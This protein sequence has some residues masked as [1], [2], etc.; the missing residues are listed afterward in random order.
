MSKSA[1]TMNSTIHTSWRLAIMALVVGALCAML[2][3]T[4]GTFTVSPLQTEANEFKTAPSAT[5]RWWVVLEGAPTLEFEG[6]HLRPLQTA[7]R[8]GQ[9]G[10]T[11]RYQATSPRVTGRRFDPQSAEV[12]SYAKALDQHREQVLSHAQRILG[13]AIQPHV[14]LHHTGNAFSA[15]MTVQ[16]ARKL[17]TLDG[18][19]SV[20]PVEVHTL[21]MDRSPQLIGATSIWEGDWN[22]WAPASDLLRARGEGMVI[23]VIDSG[24]NVDHRVFSDDPDQGA[25]HDYSNPYG[26]FLGECDQAAIT[27]N[28]KLVG[29]YDFT[30]EGTLGRDPDG[31]GHGTHVAS[32][33]AGNAWT[34]ITLSNLSG[35]FSMTGVAPHAHIISY[36]VCYDKH[37]TDSDLDGRCDGDAIRRAFEQ[38]VLDDVDVV[39]Y[40]I[41]GDAFDPW[42]ASSIPRLVLNFWSANI[43]FVTSAGNSGPEA[44]TVGQ[45]ANAPWAIAVGNSTHDR[46]ITNSIDVGTRTR[47][48][49]RPGTGPRLSGDITALA[50]RVDAVSPGNLLAC[51]PLPSDS[52]QGE[53]A[54]IERG[55]CL[56]ADKLRHAAEAGAVAVIMVNH[57]PGEAITM[58]GLEDS[59][60]PAVMIARDIGQSVLRDLQSGALSATLRAN[61]EVVISAD[62]QDS[63]ASSSSRGPTATPRDI[64]KPNLVAPGSAIFA[65]FV[66]NDDS[67]E[68]LTGTSM[69]SPQV[70]GAIALLRQIHPSWG[71]DALM[72]AV[73]TTADHDRILVE[74]RSATPDEQGG[75]RL[76][77]DRAARAGLY[78][79]VTVA[80]FEAANPARGGV[81]RTLNLPGMSHSG[82]GE[83]CELTRRLRA[84][85][86]GSWT[87][88]VEGDLPVT[89]SPSQFSLQAGE[90]QILRV[91]AMPNASSGDVVQTAQVVL[92]PQV[93]STPISSEIP[94]VTQRLSVSAAIG[95]T[96]LPGGLVLTSSGNR[97]SGRIALGSLEPVSELRFVSSSLVLP[98]QEVFELPQHGNVDDPFDGGSG[99]TAR[100]FDVAPGTMA[101]YAA[102]LAS[103]ANDI[104]LFVGR[105]PSGADVVD[106]AQEVCSSI[107]PDEIERCVISQP[108]PGRWWIVVQNWEAST[109]DA[110]DEVVLAYATVSAGNDTTLTASGPGLH[111]GGDIAI[112]VSFDQPLIAP[113][114]S[115]FGAFEVKSVVDD[116]GADESLGVVPVVLERSQWTPPATTVLFPDEP[117]ELLMQAGRSHDRLFIDVPASATA[118]RVRVQGDAGVSASLRRMDFDEV[119]ATQPAT[120][121]APGPDLVSGEGSAAGFDLLKTAPAPGR[122]YVVLTNPP[123]EDRAVTVTATLTESGG[124]LPRMALWQ[125]EKPDINQGIDFQ[126]FGTP[127]ILWY[128]YDRNGHP[129][130]Y[131]GGAP[132]RGGSSVW[133]TPVD[134]FSSGGQN[135]VNALVGRTSITAL[136]D[137]RFM[138]SWR[139]NG[140]HG[141]WIMEPSAPQACV[142]VD[143]AE[144]SFSGAWHSPNA[145]GTGSKPQGGSSVLML[146]W[147]QFHVRYFYDETGVGRWVVLADESVGPL[148]QELDVLEFRGFCP[149][150]DVVMPNSEVVGAYFRE[151]TTERTGFEMLSFKMREPFGTEI[152]LEVDIERLSDRLPC[153]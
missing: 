95:V 81:P 117:Y 141:S 67:R 15:A 131:L 105:S 62:L 101:L 143:G 124:A 142:E 83:R 90:E 25:T 70:A 30:T 43:P 69:S 38:A 118:L 129:V 130:F 61:T 132:E 57:Q 122:Y 16:E 37:P 89:V 113:D 5:G 93:S 128:S 125:P 22:P 116:Q 103:T 21:Q 19:I 18:V 34:G 97:G 109:P 13:R 114:Q 53:I 82:C 44:G 3:A 64:I 49:A 138:F 100:F 135:N 151:F 86:A 136:G 96:D 126:R 52:L 23:G 144:R 115:W 45:P 152:E 84:H 88:T 6:G 24:I 72:S 148:A 106:S 112:E 85:R 87:V 127:F 153:P 40:S 78:L 60:I 68:F 77:V 71:I 99:T 28:N 8:Q 66:P 55:D 39:N 17:A 10:L 46:R 63:L 92:T 32:I 1:L 47:I 80:E 108:E 27:C 50:R 35:S 79:P 104:D 133:V 42:R 120:P 7:R 12:R 123:S 102:T 20:T 121:S 2:P 146:P 91:Q 48:A 9:L 33:A 73:V 147:V 65:A 75:G 139:L 11:Q 59:T 41:G 150:C 134:G 137:E 29:V 76:R 107:T 149:N 56:F 119:L 145:S 51:D 36:K 54:V 58:G 98:E 110:N 14:V 74:G 4:A 31:D 94:M 140:A 111:A 26:R